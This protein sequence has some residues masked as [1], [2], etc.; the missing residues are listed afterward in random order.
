MTKG[1]AWTVESPEVEPVMRAHRDYVAGLLR[2]GRAHI[3]GPFSGDSALRGVYILSGTPEDAR[4]TAES[5]PGVIAGRYGFDVLKWMGPEGWFQRVPK[6]EDTE[7]IF[8]GFLV[9]GATT[10]AVTPEEQKL[11]MRGHLDYMGGQST[12]GKLVMA[13]PLVDGGR[14][15]GLIAYRVPTMLEAIERASADPMIK[16]GRMAPELYEWTIAKGNL[17]WIF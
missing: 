16:A 4:A 14:R 8:F 9:T 1:P 17:K 3:G 11:L 7:K 2:T 15:R 5:D 6:P 13:G 12:I 10:V